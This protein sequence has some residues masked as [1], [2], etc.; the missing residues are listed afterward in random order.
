MAEEGLVDEQQ[1]MWDIFCLH[2]WVIKYGYFYGRWSGILSTTKT[3][4]NDVF[5]P[6]F[7]EYWH[8]VQKLRCCREFSTRNSWKFNMIQPIEEKLAGPNI[9]RLGCPWSNR[10]WTWVMQSF[11][12]STVYDLIPHTWNRFEQ[13]EKNN[14]PTNWATNESSYI[15]KI[16]SQ[17][18]FC[19]V[20][21]TCTGFQAQLQSI[22]GSAQALPR[23]LG[24]A[25][26]Q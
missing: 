23:L 10:K 25:R 16:T 8:F 6:K 13:C 24:G 9:D 3:G 1:I 12:V 4:S 17:Y 26:G 20:P 7:V 22:H 14:I 11:L 19:S 21:V 15:L 18:S 5:K 2:H